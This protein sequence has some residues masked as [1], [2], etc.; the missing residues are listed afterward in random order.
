MVTINV[1]RKIFH[2]MNVKDWLVPLHEAFIDIGRS[3]AL[4]EDG[5]TKSSLMG[6]VCL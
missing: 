1:L 3:P 5:D 4:P 6:L 2:L